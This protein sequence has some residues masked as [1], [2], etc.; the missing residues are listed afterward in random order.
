[1]IPRVVGFVHIAGFDGVDYNWEY[2]G[3]TMG[4]GYDSEADIEADYVGLAALIRET[5]AAFFAVHIP[6]SLLSTQIRV[7]LSRRVTWIL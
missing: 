6:G 7:R 1:M 5:K 3:Y 4:R 2:P